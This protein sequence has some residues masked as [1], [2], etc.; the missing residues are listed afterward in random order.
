MA[1]TRTAGIG[2]RPKSEPEVREGQVPRLLTTAGSPY[3]LVEK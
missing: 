2:A 3:A 1:L